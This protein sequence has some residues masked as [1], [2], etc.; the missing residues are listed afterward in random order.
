VQKSKTAFVICP[1]DHPN[2]STRSRADWLLHVVLGPALDE[3]GYRVRRVAFDPVVKPITEEVA[4]RLYKSELVIAD[5]TGSNPNVMYELGRRHAWGAAALVVSHAST[6]P[7][8]T[9]FDIKD[10]PI[11]LH[12]EET[13]NDQLIDKYRQIVRDHALAIEKNPPT[14]RLAESASERLLIAQRLAEASGLSFVVSRGSG[15]QDHYKIAQQFVNRPCRRMFLMQRSSTL[16]L[17]AEQ[18]WEWEASF[19][20][21]VEDQV[22]KG[23]QLYHVVS[24]EGIMRHLR[25]RSSTFP[26]V[27]DV[28][29]R[30]GQFDHDGP[31]S[32][33]VQHEIVGLQ[34]KDR[35]QLFKKIP[36]ETEAQLH[37]DRQARAFIVEF[38]DGATEGLIVA[39]IG[40][41]Q[42]SFMLSGPIVKDF[43]VA[44]IDFYDDCDY[45][46]W[47]DVTEALTAAPD[48][49]A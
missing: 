6:D 35:P 26:G 20:D 24:L 40:T 28:G 13:T 9:P 19:Y 32:R 1:L 2:S 47:S 14:V 5:I 38:E 3:L 12:Y 21:I 29:D 37:P 11:I 22:R 16:V 17:G 18:G 30:L 43:L 15:R 36:R 8:E 4:E 49:P 44:L 31:E 10:F 23:A 25:R 45:L 41:S 7:H 34:G 48:P 46:Y 27:R 42:S 39:D 33:F